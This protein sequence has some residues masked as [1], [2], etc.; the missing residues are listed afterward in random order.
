MIWEPTTTPTLRE[1]L[2]EAIL[3]LCASAGVLESGELRDLAAGVACRAEELAVAPAPGSALSRMTA[4]ALGSLGRP[5]AAHRVLVMGSGLV[6]PTRWLAAHP[7][8]VWTL[9]L[10]RLL[11]HESDHLELALFPA[12]AVILKSM[13]GLWDDSSGAGQLGLRGAG[14]AARLLL[15][16]ASDPDRRLAFRRELRSFCEERLRRLG[17]GRDWTSRPDVL[18]TDPE[19]P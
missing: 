9:D 12:L 11:R 1:N 4:R 16:P 7:G 17:A 5:E 18:F 6:R 3:D 13:T 8:P 10:P 19:T 14:T 2:A 15:G